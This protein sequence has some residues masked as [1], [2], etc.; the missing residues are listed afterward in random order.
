M[1][2]AESQGFEPWVL[3]RAQH[4][5]RVSYSTTLATLQ[6][7]QKASLEQNIISAL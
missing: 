1:F 6:F 2:L 3:F 7:Y 5:S 4:F